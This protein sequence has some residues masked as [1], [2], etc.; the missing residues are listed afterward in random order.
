MGLVKVFH[1]FMFKLQNFCIKKSEK[2]RLVF[3]PSFTKVSRFVLRLSAALKTFHLSYNDVKL[4]YYEDFFVLIFFN[5]V[6]L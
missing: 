4:L 5:V 2:G 1:L 6:S 3:K